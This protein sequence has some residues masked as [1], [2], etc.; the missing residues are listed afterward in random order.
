MHAS[1]EITDEIYS[2][3]DEKEVR[4]RIEHLGQDKRMAGNTNEDVFVLFQEFL[5]WRKSRN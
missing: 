3:L 2:R 1:M 5:E 4:I